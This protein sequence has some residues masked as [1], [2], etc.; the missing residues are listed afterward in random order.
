MELMGWQ[1]SNV[2]EVVKSL[3]VGGLVNVLEDTTSCD[4]M[5]QGRHV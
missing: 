4:Y 5:K 3:S 2:G 1:Q